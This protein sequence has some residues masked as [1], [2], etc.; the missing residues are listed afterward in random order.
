MELVGQRLRLARV[1]AGL[2]LGQ[3][4]EYEGIQKGHLSEMERG[5]KEPTG[6]VIARLATRYN[7]TADYLLGLTATPSDAQTLTTAE[8]ALVAAWRAL[9]VEQRAVLVELLQAPVA[10]GELLDLVTTLGNLNQR[11]GRV[12]VIGE[13]EDAEA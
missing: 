6:A 4:F 13:E 11:L 5:K 9:P 1:R 10:V 7:C 12:R 8:Q 2:S 3:V